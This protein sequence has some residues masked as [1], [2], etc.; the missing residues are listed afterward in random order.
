[1]FP[2][3]LPDP[4]CAHSG[5]AAT[6]CV[7]DA[8][9]RLGP[10]VM[11]GIQNLDY[12]GLYA[13]WRARPKSVYVWRGGGPHVLEPPQEVREALLHGPQSPLLFLAL[14]TCLLTD[15]AHVRARPLRCQLHFSEAL[16]QFCEFFLP[17]PDNHIHIKGCDWGGRSRLF[18]LW[19]LIS[20][21]HFIVISIHYFFWRL[22]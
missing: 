22:N 10:L 4:R 2:Y 1:M 5:C 21:N 9:P 17:P 12:P 16:R 7:L 15:E 3:C 11:A 13:V 19:F 6:C 18:S 20:K 14:S 8:K